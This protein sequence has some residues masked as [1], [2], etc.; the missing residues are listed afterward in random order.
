MSRDITLLKQKVNKVYYL[1][2]LETDCC[3][4]MKLFYCDFGTSW[5]ISYINHITDDHIKTS[6]LS[7]KKKKNDLFVATSVD[8]IS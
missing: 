2:P 8:V 4:S 5:K 1:L 7:K 3:F 6:R